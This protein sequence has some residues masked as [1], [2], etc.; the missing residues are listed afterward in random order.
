MPI[1]Y[2]SNEIHINQD[3]VYGIRLTKQT[4]AVT[5]P[6]M[7]VKV[8]SNDKFTPAA[9]A[10]IGKGQLYVVLRVSGGGKPTN[11]DI[12]S[13]ETIDVLTVE[14]GLKC[15]IKGVMTGTQANGV[16]VTL[17]STAG[18]ITAATTNSGSNQVIAKVSRGV[19]G[20]ESGDRIAVTFEKEFYTKS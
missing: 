20:A 18:S 16:E 7:I 15:S 5:R 14:N 6:G 3:A 11:A 8:D 9:Y 1:S 10:D 2:E 12:A 17:S 4:S 13:G 19:T